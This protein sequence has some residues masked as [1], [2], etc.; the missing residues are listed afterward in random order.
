MARLVLAVLAPS[1]G[2][3]RSKQHIWPAPN[4]RSRP[5]TVPA[6]LPDVRRRKLY[7]SAPSER[8]RAADRRHR[9]S[10]RLERVRITVPSAQE[11]EQHWKLSGSLPGS[12]STS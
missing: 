4:S 2:W 10:L 1:N 11:V 9:T 12:C 3:D 5:A 6:Q 8:M 7:V